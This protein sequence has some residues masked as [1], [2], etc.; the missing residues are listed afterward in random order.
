MRGAGARCRPAI[1]GPG[2]RDDNPRGENAHMKDEHPNPQESGA[3]GHCQ[4][5]IGFCLSDSDP[6]AG[7]RAPLHNCPA[8]I[9][10]T[11]FFMIR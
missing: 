5:I 10:K 3:S 2:I 6:G 11:Y 7:F 9:M 8:C 4:P 1:S